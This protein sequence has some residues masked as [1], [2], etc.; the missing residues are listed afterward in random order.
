MQQDGITA[1]HIA[2]NNVKED[3]IRLLL[4]RKADPF[5][6]YGNLLD[7]ISSGTK[8]QLA[9][10]CKLQNVDLRRTSISDLPRLGQANTAI[11]YESIAAVN[12]M[13]IDNQK[14]MTR[15]IYIA[16][17]LSNGTVPLIVHKH[18]QYHKV[19]AQWIPKH[20]TPA[21]KLELIVNRE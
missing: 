18:L 17:S 21:H 2:V 13:I 15:A 3:A 9:F 11:G 14:A 8:R 19:S 12:E 7:D 6:P 20:F 16:L 4:S 10:M 1:L 5:I